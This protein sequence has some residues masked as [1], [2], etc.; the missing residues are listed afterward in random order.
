MAHD[1]ILCTSERQFMGYHRV[2]FTSSV[3]NDQMATRSGEVHGEV[4]S[5]EGGHF[6]FQGGKRHDEEEIFAAKQVS[7]VRLEPSGHGDNPAIHEK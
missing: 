3:I 7:A 2:P 6:T 5:G 4:S 1:E